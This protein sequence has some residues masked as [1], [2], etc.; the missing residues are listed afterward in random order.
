VGDV[1]KVR[2]KLMSM[3]WIFVWIYVLPMAALAQQGILFEQGMSWAKI[4]EKAKRENK[5]I[6]VDCYATWCGPCK[7]MDKEVYPEKAAG[8]AFNGRFISVKMQMDSSRMDGVASKAAYGDAHEIKEQYKPEGYP[9]FLFFDPDGRLTYRAVGERDL[10]A[11]IDL[12]NMVTDPQQNYYLLLQRFRQGDRAPDHMMRAAIKG[13][14][15][16]DTL[17]AQRIA[18]TYLA[19]Y[20]M[21]KS[22]SRDRI[23]FMRRFTRATTDPGFA[24][25][26]ANADTIDAVEQ[27]GEFVQ[28]FVHA[29]IFK[30]EVLPVMVQDSSSGESPDWQGLYHNI[31]GKYGNYYAQR[32]IVAARSSWGLWRKDWAMYTKYL[33]QFMEHYC[34]KKAPLLD[35]ALNNYAWAVFTY[36]SDRHELEEALEW[37]GRAILI[38]PHPDYMDTYANLLYKLGQRDKA[39]E[40]EAIAVKMDPGSQEKADNA[41]RMKEG[42]PT[43]PKLR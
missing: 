2:K 11:F 21:D 34:P 15:L 6:F 31:S 14:E 41:T 28:G 10:K 23:D 13:L 35:L 9:T 30:E 24:F 3:R 7:K 39:M 33:V 29:L 36:S 4:L 19:T 22:F 17:N 12:A 37:T 32:V 8:L 42:T 25:F 26:Y 18:E 1:G 20:F 43:W 16:G 27:N 5:F 38:D 40:W